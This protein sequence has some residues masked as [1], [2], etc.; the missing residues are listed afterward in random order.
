MREAHFSTPQ[1]KTGERR[2]REQAM[3]MGIRQTLTLRQTR[4]P[5]ADNRLGAV[6]HL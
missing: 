6:G 3:V 2:R 5:G 1:N 4:V